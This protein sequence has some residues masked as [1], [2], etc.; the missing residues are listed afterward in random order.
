[1]RKLANIYTYYKSYYNTFIIPTIATNDV[2][3]TDAIFFYNNNNNNKPQQI[4]SLLFFIHF[5]RDY[6]IVIN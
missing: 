2:V 4:S 5:I 1:M 6:L 3:V